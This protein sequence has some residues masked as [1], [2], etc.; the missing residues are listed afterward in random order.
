M[1]RL[2]LALALVLLLLVPPSSFG[3]DDEAIRKYL[4]DLQASNMAVFYAEC[5]LKTGEAVTGKAGLV[6]PVAERSGR[7]IERNDR[8]IVVNSAVVTLA[9][10]KWDMEGA[11][12]GIATV[13]RVTSLVRQLLESQ[14]HLV[15]PQKIGEIVSSS[16]KS[17]CS[18]TVAKE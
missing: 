12:G 2:P 9:G 17:T 13:Q 14:F 7:Y 16:P 18:T 10:G 11:Q 15:Q 6:F 4:G 3:G 1:S 5:K 8:M